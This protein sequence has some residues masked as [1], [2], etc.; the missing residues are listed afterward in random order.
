MASTFL[1]PGQD[2]PWFG[3]RATNIATSIVIVSF[4]LLVLTI[5]LSWQKRSPE[6]F[7][8]ACGRDIVDQHMMDG[9]GSV[10][11][12]GK[13]VD[14]GISLHRTMVWLRFFCAVGANRTNSY[15]DL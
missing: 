10:D 9:I 4:L 8:F 7:A 5:Q 15:P 13:V 6:P 3:R 11:G 1:D 14:D 12:E 2:G